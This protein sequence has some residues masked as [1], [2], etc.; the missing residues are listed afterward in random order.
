MINKWAK[1]F[2]FDCSQRNVN[3]NHLPFFGLLNW[4]RLQKHPLTEEHM[5]K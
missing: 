2:N 5:R 1:I 4:H 3:L